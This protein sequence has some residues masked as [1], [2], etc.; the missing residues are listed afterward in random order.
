[1]LTLICQYYVPKEKFRRDEID[2]CFRKNI[3]NPL[4]TKMLIFFERKEDMSLLPDLPKI[5][6]RFYAERLTYG[7]WLKETNKMPTGTLSLIINS[8]IYLTESV[9]HLISSKE[10]LLNEKKFVALTRYNPNTEG[11]G[12]VLN[13]NPHWTQDTWAI[14]K[15]EQGFSSALIQ[16]TSFEL[17]Q[18][19]CDN[20]IVAV[21][22]SYGFNVTNPCGTVHTIHLQADE[23]RSYD[24]RINKLIGLHAFSYANNSVFEN[25][26]LEFDLLSRNL[27]PYEE[28]RVNNW[29]NDAKSYLLKPEAKEIEGLKEK[30]KKTV[31]V[32]EPSFEPMY[33]WPSD[34]Y[35]KA[36]GYDYIKRKSFSVIEYK[37]LHSFDQQ[38]KVFED[39]NYWYFYDQYW[40]YVRRVQRNNLRFDKQDNSCLLILFSTG[41]L[42]AV[43][44][45]E[46]IS[47]GVEKKHST[48]V[49]FWQMPAKTE[50]DAYERHQKL[51]GPQIENSTV[52]TYV[53][54][55]WATIIDQL[56][57]NPDLAE[58]AIPKVLIG[59]LAMR[60]KTAR[61]ILKKLGAKLKVHTVCQQIYW[62]DLAEQFIKLEITDLWLAHKTK[63]ADHKDSM[64]LHAW[65]LYAVNIE[66]PR[67]RLGLK[68]I[69]VNDRKYLASFIGAYMD[70]Y[71]NDARPKMVNALKNQP[72][73]CLKLNNMWHFNEEVY[74]Q[75]LGLQVE[76]ISTSAQFS[77]NEYNEVLS[78]S[79]F[80][81]CP[82]GAGPNTLRLWESLA[83]GS[84]PVVISDNYEF[85]LLIK[86]DGSNFNWSDAVVMQGES[87]LIHLDQKLRSYSKDILTRMSQA[88]Q[89]AYGLTLNKTCF[90]KLKEK[91]NVDFLS[92]IPKPKPL[93]IFIPYY[94]P[95]DKYFWRSTHHGL[96]DLVMAWHERG[97]CD[98]EHHDGPY[99]WI[100]EI[101]L[102]LLFDRDQ[103][104][105][106]IDKKK[107][108]PRW[109]GEVS[110]KYAF[111]TNEYGLEND[112]NLKYNY[113][114]YKPLELEIRVNSVPIIPYEER[115][116]DSIFLGAVENETQEYFRNKFKNWAVSIDE[117]YIADK[118]NKNEK[119]KYTFNEYLD[120]VAHSKFGISFRGN[121]PKCYREIEYAAMGTPMIITEGVD[122]A[123]PDPLLEGVH[124]YKAKNPDDIFEIVNS[125]GREQW[126]SMSKNCREWYLK[127]FT[128]QAMFDILS[129]S[130]HNCNPNLNK[131]KTIYIEK[132]DLLSDLELTKK[133][134]KIFNPNIEV[135]D[136]QELN[137]SGLVFKAGD[138]FVNELPYV[139]GVS[140]YKYYVKKNEI[141]Q[142]K[143]SIT[144]SNLLKNKKLA[145][146]LKWRLP[147]HRVSLSLNGEQLAIEKFITNDGIILLENKDINYE[148]VPDY[149]FDRCL[150]AK[151][152][153]YFLNG[154]DSLEFPHENIIYSVL[155]MSKDEKNYEFDVLESCLE[156]YAIFNRIPSDSDCLWRLFKT[157]EYEGYKFKSL[158][159]KY[160]KSGVLQESELKG[161]I[162]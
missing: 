4:I 133:S 162:S 1:M 47:I 98:I 79:K 68:A 154:S 48:D 27:E 148:I 11:E 34:D 128:H 84:I 158:K 100:N 107:P 49:L 9:S 136:N 61:K 54:L 2:T 121:G 13:S 75:Q 18:P 99:Y 152:F 156:F 65:P 41:F 52:N 59:T 157:W 142:L 58:D 70:H 62:N 155:S 15:P 160:L 87:E 93:K 7:F 43:L 66:T 127:N 138:I 28:I 135:V 19:G 74:N 144:D 60:I 50:F 17:G 126:V 8:D 103:V 105:D 32:Y 76:E 139:K 78:D 106:L 36:N 25:A 149:S 82:I 40:P 80:S 45:L 125:V 146:L 108:Y 21:M 57:F 16:E 124:Y 33:I 5:E 104:A 46:G 119:A 120:K 3:E 161:L 30:Y 64:H 35:V 123:Y 110:Y 150:S 20:K 101:G 97:W 137:V 143:K 89:I 37:L 73:Y 71:G 90:G 23:K 86:D 26:R 42:P 69:P 39:Q 140:I 159:I 92:S 114:S 95:E 153:D 53:G 117:Y 44:E 85:P 115:N 31:E 111:F 10:Y 38:Y 51:I 113:W 122:V 22:H 102:I 83:M 72:D 67:R 88:C 145:T 94:G 118:L 91:I 151:Y 112:R 130:V 141:A 14:V 55:P 132:N 129:Q 56:K 96:Y 24:G 77:V 116:I 6:K 147:K 63:D 29:I 134:F 131:P 81:L 109:E 12:F